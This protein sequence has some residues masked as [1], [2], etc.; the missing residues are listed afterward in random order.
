MTAIYMRRIRE[1]LMALEDVPA[2]W[3]AQTEAMLSA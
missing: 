2:R 3:R 1:G